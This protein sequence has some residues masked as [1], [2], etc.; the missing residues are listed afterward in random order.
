[1]KQAGKAVLIRSLAQ[2]VHD[3][4]VLIDS[5]VDA[6]ENRGDFKL[7]RRSLIVD[8]YKRQLVDCCQLLVSQ[9]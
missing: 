8:V 3:Q 7:A 6:V 1:M 9:S 5:D 2:H 4:L